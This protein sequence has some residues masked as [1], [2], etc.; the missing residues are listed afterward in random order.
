MISA[1]VFLSGFLPFFN[2]DY[3]HFVFSLLFSIIYFHATFFLAFIFYA[4]C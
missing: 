1:I 4:A 2:I 3:F